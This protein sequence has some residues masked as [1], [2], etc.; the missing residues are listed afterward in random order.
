MPISPSYARGADARANTP[1]IDTVAAANAPRTGDTAASPMALDSPVAHGFKRTA[2]GDIKGPEGVVKKA[3]VAL[4]AHKRNKSMDIHSGSRI[5]EVCG[6]VL[7]LI[8]QGANAY[9]AIRTT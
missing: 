3:N 8:L 7:V 9:A 6:R 4:G 5:G 1:R 2:A